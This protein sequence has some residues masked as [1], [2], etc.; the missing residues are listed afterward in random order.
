MTL[1][2]VRENQHPHAYH[3]FCICMFFFPINF[4][5]TDFSAPIC[6]FNMHLMAMA[7]GSELFSLS[8]IFVDMSWHFNL[9]RPVTT[10]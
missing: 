7:I 4:F 8:A 2:C 10:D 9:K 3:S 1:Y 6:L 5:T